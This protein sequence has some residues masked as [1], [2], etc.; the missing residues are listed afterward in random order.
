MPDFTTVTD[1]QLD[2][3]HQL[4]TPI[5]SNC[6]ERLSLRAWTEGYMRPEIRSIYPKQPTTLGYAVTLTISAARQATN[7]AP[8]AT[9]GRASSRSWTTPHRGPRSRLPQ[10]HRLILGRSPE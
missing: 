3:L 9:T 4:D 5:I 2:A 10:P 6:L 8:D 1:A 7:P